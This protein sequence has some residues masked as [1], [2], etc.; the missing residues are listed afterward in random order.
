M[1]NPEDNFLHANNQPINLCKKITASL[2]SPGSPYF[3]PLL[4]G[5]FY[6][7]NLNSLQLSKTMCIAK[8]EF[9]II[10]LMRYNFH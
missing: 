1:M 4:A 8:D 10:F 9:F 3:L 2:F 6:F 7:L 5:L